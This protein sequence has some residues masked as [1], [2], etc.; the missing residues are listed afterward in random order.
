MMFRIMNSEL[1]STLMELSQ[2]ILRKL[3]TKSHVLA[4]FHNYEAQH[5]N[6][7]HNPGPLKIF[8]NVYLIFRRWKR[9]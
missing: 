9:N 1:H 6:E 7:T 3:Y 2:M 4:D 5:V 8:F